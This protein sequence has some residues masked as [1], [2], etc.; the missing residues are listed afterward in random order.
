M[1][2]TY[3]ALIPQTVGD[4]VREPGDLVPEARDWAY[5]DLYIRDTKIAPVLVATLPKQ[6]QDKLNAWEKEQDELKELMEMEAREAEAR[7]EA[8]LVRL[9][10]EANTMPEP[11]T[12]PEGP[13]EGKVT[14]RRG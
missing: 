11:D 9:A 12:E 13:M 4:D 5:R 3:Y 6:V 1:K 2:L 10:Q 14:I 8:E 7:N